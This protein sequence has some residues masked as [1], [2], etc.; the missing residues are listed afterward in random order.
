VTADEEEEYE[1]DEGELEPEAGGP[2]LTGLS[3]AYLAMLPLFA[4]YEWAGAVVPGAPRN[5]AE[6]VLSLWLRPL[7]AHAASAR[8]LL[9]L[10]GAMVALALVRRAGGRVRAGVARIVLEG[11]GFALILG[12]LL[13]LLTRLLGAW[14]EPLEGSWDPTQAQ[15]PELARAALLFGGSAYEE[16]LFRVG[17]YSFL[18]WL[19][20][21]F[22]TALNLS[23]RA[24]RWFGELT[25]LSGSAVLFALIH[26]QPVADLLG[27]GAPP[28][29]GPLCAWL[30]LAGLL[31]GLLFR[32]RGP[33]VAAWAHGLFN[34]ALLVG[35]DPDVLT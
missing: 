12:P 27:P 13:V 31:L 24:G 10:V 32:L 22:L 16:L 6:M 18:Y 11:A 35:I 14:I 17:A 2:V 4:A 29:D 19:T 3:L 26:M 7:G 23:E 30:L 28:F 5:G 9:L 25:G 34:V 21:R 1:E 20:L 8:R 15:P 33:G